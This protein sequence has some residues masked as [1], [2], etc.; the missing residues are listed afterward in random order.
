MWL[1]FAGASSESSSS[2]SSSEED[3]KS[4]GLAPVW[5]LRLIA[6][7]FFAFAAARR[8]SR[9]RAGLSGSSS[10][11]ESEED[12]SSSSSEDSFLA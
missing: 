7:S 3:G 10:S 1:G 8:W 2:S 9:V 5:A 11:D 12:S 6:A 4:P